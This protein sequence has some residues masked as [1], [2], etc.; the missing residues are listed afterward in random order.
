MSNKT[1]RSVEEAR[2]QTQTIID[3]I[4]QKGPVCRVAEV[5]SIDE[6]ARSVELAFSSEAPVM[7]WWGEETLSHDPAHVR[8]D[9]L[10]DG[11]ALLWNHNWNDQR[12]VIDGARIDSDRKGRAVVRFSRTE[13]GEKLW[14]DI[15][16]KIKRHVSV[17]YWIH[18]MQIVE[19]VDDLER[20]LITDWEP[21]EISIVSVPADISVG[22][23]RNADIPAMV[24]PKVAAE[25]GSVTPK[26]AAHPNP[27]NTTDMTIKNVRNAKGDLVRAEVDD[28]GNIIREIEVIEAATEAARSHAQ[29]GIDTER[30]RVKDINAMAE[31]YSKAIPNAEELARK[32]IDDGKSP[33]DFQAV[34]LDAADKRMAQPLNEQSRNA[35][36]GL[37]DREVAEFSILRVARALADPTSRSAREAAAME[38]RASE[39]ARERN[40]KATDNF[41]IPTDVLRRAVGGDFSR[42]ALSTSPTTNGNGGKIVDTS[43]MV[44]SFIELLRKRTTILRLGRVM[45]GL[46][47]NVD[48]PKQ[49]AGATGYWVG[50]GANVGEGNLALGNI[51][52]S[53]KTAGAYSDLTRRLLMQSSM[54]AEALVRRDL[55]TALGQ[56]ID[57]AGY[58]GTGTD[59]QPLG[60]SNY[61]GINAVPFVGANPTHGELV[62]METQIALDDADAD[63]MRYVA[64][65]GFRGYAKQTLKDDGVSG[66]IWEPGNTVNGY[67]CDITNQINSGDVFFGNFND[68]IVA[69]W[70]SLELNVDRAALA[71]SGGLR[72]IVFQDVDFA[73]RRTQSFCLGRPASV[74]GGGS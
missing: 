40:G 34:L 24:A 74:G 31:R 15:K 42:A 69:M 3:E 68:L 52:L 37:T 50:E 16:D 39:A 36:I 57:L 2:A 51:L 22:V 49:T 58:Y 63:G 20:W 72:L 41:V 23:G 9:R 11:G 48:I 12:G 6:E 38:F 10:N 70:G 71:L 1:V 62:D 43:L 47:G 17:G 27:E 66:Y 5:V 59:Q 61:V 55:A 44:D 28:D 35:D 33:A 14:L 46:V 53:P 30:T 13:E 60:I 56:M 4:R 45:A 64:P 19:I 18:A 54:D 29:R 73:L 25:T 7:R 67:G 32:A 65:S 26:R 8:L 21:Y